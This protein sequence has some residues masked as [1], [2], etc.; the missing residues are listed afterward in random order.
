[1]CWKFVGLTS[2]HSQKNV[3]D[4]CDDRWVDV[5]LEKCEG[6]FRLLTGKRNKGVETKERNEGFGIPSI[7]SSPT[8]AISSLF[9]PLSP[10]FFL[11]S[12]NYNQVFPVHANTP[13]K[14][15][16]SSLPFI[17]LLNPPFFMFSFF[18]N[19]KKFLDRSCSFLKISFKQI[20]RKTS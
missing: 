18:N 20:A 19:L 5:A 15:S 9:W 11:G 3:V 1:M 16:V 8:K 7:P 14:S 12:L 4:S 2:C 10:N 6:C 17:A 13:Q